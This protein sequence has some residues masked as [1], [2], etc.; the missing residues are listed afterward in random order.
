MLC[1][2]NSNNLSA[3]YAADIASGTGW[4]LDSDGC[5]HLAGAVTNPGT[6]GGA[7]WYAQRDKVKTVVAE[8]GA[9]INN[10]QCLF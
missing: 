5:L 1:Y 9:S 10:G 8:S 7:P 3:A 2:N 4:H 6:S